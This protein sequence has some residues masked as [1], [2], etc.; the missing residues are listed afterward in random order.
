MAL[1]R[2]ENMARIK[3]ANT[4]PELAVRQRLWAAGYRYRLHVK[5]PGGRADLVIP[6][7]SFALFIDGCFWHGCPEHYVRPRTSNPFWDSKLR[8]NVDRDRRQTLKLLDA[9]W[10]VIRVWEHEVAEAPEQ[11]AGQIITALSDDRFAAVSTLRVV[12][13]DWLDREGRLERR[14]CEELLDGSRTLI[15]ERERSTAKVGRV[16]G[17]RV[18]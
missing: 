4:G 18:G 15:E 7:R 12:R 8:E 11:V 14:T 13:V 16:R 1:T 17:K 10:R 9:G 5:T 3:G 6:R 2:S